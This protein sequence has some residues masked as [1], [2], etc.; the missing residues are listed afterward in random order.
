MATTITANG[1]NFPDGS[2]GTPSIGGSD[3]NTGLFTGSDIIG[4]ATGGS[5]RLKIDASG[6]VNIANDSGKLQLGASND[7]KIYH[8]GTH[9]YLDSSNGNIYLRVNSTE[10][11][12]KCTENGNVEI[13]Y[14]GS[15][16]LETTSGGVNVIGALTVNGSAINTDLVADT[17]PQLGGNLDVNTKNIN[18]GDSASSSDDRLNFGADTD[19]S[20][21]HNGTNNIISS[22]TS[23][24]QL[25]MQANS[26]VR[27]TGTTT[28]IMDENN[29]ETCAVFASDGAVELYYDNSKKFETQSAGAQLFGN[30]TVGTDGGAILLSNP[31]G[32][33]PKLQ[34]NAGSL[35]FYTN[36]SLRMSLGHGGN[37]LFQDNRKAEFGASSDLQIFHDGSDSHIKDTGTGG[38]YISTDQF[39]VR[40]A[41]GST[42]NMEIKDN[43]QVLVPEVYNRT[44][45]SSVNMRVDSDGELRRSTS[46]KRYKKDITDATWGLAE[47]LKLKP[48]TYKSNATGKDAD[49]KTYGGFIAEDVHDLGLTEFVDYNEKNEPDAL[50][51]GNM[52]AL[53]A[54]AIQDLNAKVEAL[55]AA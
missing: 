46:S 41:A 55:E 17:S 45:G 7:L 22:N 8:N 19:L 50:A 16:K 15:K 34:E 10:N 36:N 4:F 27:L 32:F 47:L 51:Y 44:T 30:L 35:E 54:K 14:D 43:G 25:I 3:T 9:N 18:F 29:S 21:Y 33:S 13:A 52:V 12:I 49:D 2:A 37:L 6:N 39:L 26:E 20:I 42:I 1:I 31:D 23:G 5:E 53:M 40:N 28:R 11:A 38:L 48:I 24:K